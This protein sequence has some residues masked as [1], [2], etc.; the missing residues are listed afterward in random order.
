[1]IGN[2]EGA[3][4][5]FEEGGRVEVAVLPRLLLIHVMDGKRRLSV[6]LV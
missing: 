3:E 5:F 6:I 4:E 2:S 1:M